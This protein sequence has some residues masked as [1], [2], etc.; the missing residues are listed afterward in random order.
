ME[1]VWL[2]LAWF[3]GA[4]FQYVQ[5]LVD[6]TLSYFIARVHLRDEDLAHLWVAHYLATHYPDQAISLRTG[7][8]SRL[9]NNVADKGVYISQG[10]TQIDEDLTS[11]T[12]FP[13]PGFHV[14]RSKE[15][16]FFWYRLFEPND[17]KTKGWLGLY[18]LGS[19]AP[20]KRLITTARKE[21][22][23]AKKEWIDVYSEC[24]F[25]DSWDR[26]QHRPRVSFDSVIMAPGMMDHLVRDAR[27]FMQSREWYDKHG[28]PH[29][30]G[31]LFY[32]EPGCGKST[33]V[34]ALASYLDVDICVIRISAL[35]DYSLAKLCRTAATGAL[36][37]IEDVD[38]VFHEAEK[39]EDRKTQVTPEGLSHVL[40][41][42]SGQL[43][44]I[45]VMTT[46]HPERLTEV[47]TRAG[48][49]D[50]K[51]EFKPLE[52]EQALEMAKQ[53]FK[54]EE[55]AHLLTMERL[56]KPIR[57]AELQNLLIKSKGDIDEFY[58]ELE[59]AQ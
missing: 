17:H 30:R 7:S 41:S 28:I 26:P 4:F 53:Y 50:M 3:A 21:Y 14:V 10:T 31:Y 37:V 29:R 2:V 45:V 24:G 27:W 22:L 6:D 46:N 56:K 11:L 57:P 25:G 12:P 48:R 5:T 55:V 8:L 58:L 39:K 43:G 54:P 51:L 19:V 35:R 59:R 36:L 40:D 20:L 49:V 38:L 47:I 34:L 15:Y 44:H 18:R 16:G 23:E 42:A 52:P 13:A 32:G 33:T 9:Q 1:A